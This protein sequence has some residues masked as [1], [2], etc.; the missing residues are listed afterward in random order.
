[1]TQDID[2]L[3]ANALSEIDAL[4]RDAT[5]SSEVVRKALATLAKRLEE[6]EAVICPFASPQ[7]PQARPIHFEAARRWMESK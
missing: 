4:E 1:M 7:N 6:A 5:S 3:V 2:K